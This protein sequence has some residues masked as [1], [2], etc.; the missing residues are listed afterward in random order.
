LAWAVIDDGQAPDLA[1][2]RR[3]IDSITLAALQASEGLI[4]QFDSDA[5]E[6]ESALSD[7]AGAVEPLRAQLR[8][9]LRALQQ[10]LEGERDDFDGILVRGARVWITAGMSYGDEPTEFFPALG[11]LELAGVLAAAGFDS[12]PTSSQETEPQPSRPASDRRDRLGRG[13]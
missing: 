7:E 1:A 9:D 4:D 3:H 11:R 5:L 6:S 10:G 2:A 13:S 8:A 12:E